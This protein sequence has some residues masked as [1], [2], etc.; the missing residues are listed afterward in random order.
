MVYKVFNGTVE[1]LHFLAEALNETTLSFSQIVFSKHSSVAIAIVIAV[2]VSAPTSIVS[3]LVAAFAGML[4]IAF[5]VHRRV[6]SS[7]LIMNSTLVGLLLGAYLDYSPYSVAVVV[8]AGGLAGLLTLLL[9]SY[10]KV[11]TLPFV[12]CLTLIPLL[13]DLPAFQPAGSVLDL[14]FKSFILDIFVKPLGAIFGL[15]SAAAS[16]ILLVGIAINSRSAATAC[17][18]S[19]LSGSIVAMGFGADIST[20]ATGIFGVNTILAMLG[21][22]YSLRCSL[23]SIVFVVFLTALLEQLLRIIG[24]SFYT[25]P[26]MIVLWM[27]SSLSKRLTRRIYLSN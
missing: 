21:A 26:F 9:R 1:K 2:S 17:I 4:G 15:N 25:L 5:F 12:V 7:D 6:V 13:F 8:V 18:L 16:L 23:P 24:L 27:Y 19:G 14:P 3:A 20:V 10:F 11:Y 22:H